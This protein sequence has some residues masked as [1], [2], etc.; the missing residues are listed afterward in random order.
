ME[1]KIAVIIPCI[2]EEENL[3]ELLPYLKANSKSLPVDI[4]VCD[5]GSVDNSESVTIQNSCKF[6]KSPI[7]SRAAQ[8]NLGANN[9]DAN[10]F[11]FVHADARP[12]PD[13]YN[14]IIDSVSRKGAK[15]G[16]FRFKF[17]SNKLLLKMNSW[18][19]RFN[20]FY[21]RGGDTGLF[22]ERDF[23]FS[24]GAYDEYWTIMEE[25]DLLKRAK[26]SN[27]N[28]H[29]IQK[30]TLVSARKY[31]SNSWLRVQIA[32]LIAI[33][34]F[35]RNKNPNDILEQYKRNLNLFR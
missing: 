30:D 15:F 16:G 19:T 33:Q 1:L 4:I 20:I 28:F 9:S 32:N 13:F 23:F 11:F 29:L 21:F 10:I 3:R 34:A 17:K 22:F 14:L 27:E 7:K 26:L 5:G 24:L 25:Y 12:H 6:L 8:M 31:D 35:K 2:Q 18:F